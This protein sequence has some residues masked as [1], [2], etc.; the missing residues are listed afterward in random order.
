MT[1][2][3]CLNRNVVHLSTLCAAWLLLWLSECLCPISPAHVPFC[4][5]ILPLAPSAPF[6]PFA[7]SFSSLSPLSGTG[8]PKSSSFLARSIFIFAQSW[9]AYVFPISPF[10]CGSDFISSSFSSFPPFPPFSSFSAS[11]P[12]CFI[13]RRKFKMFYYCWLHLNDSRC[14]GKWEMAVGRERVTP[15]TKQK[16]KVKYQKRG[17]MESNWLTDCQSNRVCTN[18][19][20]I[21]LP[22][23]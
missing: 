11:F 19:F 2:D 5:K 22:K 12:L 20:Q 3:P 10:R 13:S 21:D 8:I 14:K 23:D 6:A 16:K 15:P 17:E 18:R 9:K 4:P 7:P 1:P